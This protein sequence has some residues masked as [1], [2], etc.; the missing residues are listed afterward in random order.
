M[1]PVIL[2]LTAKPLLCFHV[3]V[4]GPRVGGGRCGAEPP[5][6][7]R[8]VQLHPD[9]RQFDF[10]WL[11]ARTPHGGCI[12]RAVSLTKSREMTTRKTFPL[13]LV[14]A[15]FSGKDLDSAGVAVGE[16]GGEDGDGD[17]ASGAE[18]ST[19]LIAAVAVMALCLFVL[20]GAGAVFFLR[21]H[22][23]Q[24]GSSDALQRKGSQVP[25]LAT[26]ALLEEQ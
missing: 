7:R 12:V 19:A 20:V 23:E 5:P 15:G 17:D 8:C 18:T 24:G 10:V 14:D 16:A 13:L 11:P 26:R 22:G 1:S 4:H 9:G 2:Q 3:K 25:C 21:R 6:R